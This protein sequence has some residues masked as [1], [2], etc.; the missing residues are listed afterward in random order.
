MTEDGGD[1]K[2]S[3]VPVNFR[4]LDFVTKD[5]WLWPLV[6]QKRV[7]EREYAKANPSYKGKTWDYDRMTEDWFNNN[8]ELFMDFHLKFCP[9]TLAKK[10]GFNKKKKSKKEKKRKRTGLRLV[11]NRKEKVSLRTQHH[12][13]E[14]PDCDYEGVFW[15][16]LDKKKRKKRFHC[17]KCRQYNEKINAKGMGKLLKQK[18]SLLKRRAS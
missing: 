14:N 15:I 11:D 3:L 9:P 8:P 18:K 7:W 2:F 5:L 10:F 16:E 12:F 1:L 13:C 17:P 6:A 4:D